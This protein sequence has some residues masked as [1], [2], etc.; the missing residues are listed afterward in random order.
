MYNSSRIWLGYFSSRYL[1]N[2][3]TSRLLKMSGWSSLTPT[4]WRFDVWS[5]RRSGVSSIWCFELSST[6]WRFDDSSTF[7]RSDVLST[8][9]HS[10]LLTEPNFPS[11][12]VC[13][14]GFGLR[15]QYVGHA[16]CA[17]M[18]LRILKKILQVI[19]RLHKLGKVK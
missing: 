1:S 19:V 12:E 16:C 9:R 18:R 2:L 11:T 10:E 13:C 15:D 4:F 7:W 3:G 14:L 6:F 17:M 5:V 8:L